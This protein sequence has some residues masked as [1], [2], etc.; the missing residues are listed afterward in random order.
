ME[1]V[2]SEPFHHLRLYA[3]HFQLVHATLHISC[4]LILTEDL[5]A[6]FVCVHLQALHTVRCPASCPAPGGVTLH[7]YCP[8]I[9]RVV[10]Y[11]TDNN[12]VVQR[13]P[14]FFSIKGKRC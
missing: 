14:G 8:P 10:L 3:C 12:R 13:I 6:L 9:K 1:L 5:A 7:L 11:E 4:A 2:L